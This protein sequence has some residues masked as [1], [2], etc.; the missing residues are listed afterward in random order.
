MVHFGGEPEPDCGFFRNTIGQPESFGTEARWDFRELKAKGIKIAYTTAGCFD[1][2]RQSVFK[3]HNGA[4]TKCPWELRS[5]RCSDDSNVVWGESVSAMCDLVAV[6]ADYGHEWRSRSFVYREPLT[7]ALD[8]SYWTPDL[9]I[10]EKWRLPRAQ[11]ELIVYH[12]MGHA[13]LRRFGGRD[14][15]GTGAIVAAIDRLRLEGVKVRLEHAINVPDR[16]VRFI[17]AQADVIVDQLV[18]G[19]YRARA[20][21]GMMLGKPTICHIDRSE[22]GGVA[23]LDCWRECPLVDAT[24]ETIYSVLKRL[25]ASAEHR[26]QIGHASREYALRWHAAESAAE[27]YEQVYDRVMMDLPVN[28]SKGGNI[29]KQ[30]REAVAG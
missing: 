9:H 8:P 12:D 30:E 24:E 20:R 18:I 29:P 7:T 22:P 3:R 4:C 26:E 14:I 28:D 16:H 15:R 6:E 5:D 10:P 13:A 1:G 25:L 11:D 23:E 19:R 21:E 17:Q 2:V 27:R